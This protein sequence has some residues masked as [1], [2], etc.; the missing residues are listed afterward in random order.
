MAYAPTETRQ[1]SV[2]GKGP[3]PNF[4]VR[5]VDSG[6]DS[7]VAQ[8]EISATCYFRSADEF[9]AL[10]EHFTDRVVRDIE[11]GDWTRV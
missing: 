10:L 8:V 2:N 6:A 7:G 5:V 11:T 1:Q 9:R 4:E 3:R